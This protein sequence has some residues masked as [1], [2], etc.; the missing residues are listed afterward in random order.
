MLINDVKIKYV[1][2]LL[3]WVCLY[4]VVILCNWVWLMIVLLLKSCNYWGDLVFEVKFFKVII[5]EEMIQEKLD[6]AV[7]CIFMLYCVYMVKLM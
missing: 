3:L 2:W 5:G 4:N 6:L 7:E 1:K